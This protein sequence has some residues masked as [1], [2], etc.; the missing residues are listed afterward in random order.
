MI[1]V[2]IVSHRQ[3]LLVEALISDL[4]RYCRD[5]ELMV[6]LNV[7][8]ADLEQELLERFPTLVFRNPAPAGFGTNHNRAFARS[9][10]E[11]FCVLNPD[12]RLTS[13]PFPPLLEQLNLSKVGIAAPR[14]IDPFGREE[15]N[16]RPFP[17]PWSLLGKALGFPR[18]RE[19]HTGSSAFSPDWVAGIFMVFQRDSFIRVGGFDER[20][21]LYYEDVD[22]CARMRLQGYDIRLDPRASVVH[23]ARRQSHRDLRYLWWHVRSALTYFSSATHRRA[24]AL[25]G[26]R[27]E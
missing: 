13:D 18:S 19:R 15:D 10:G 4:N 16:A 11:Y 20:Y 21:F 27:D 2:S 9:S 22:L 23:A 12:V 1:S 26:S 6:T 25:R 5:L 14:V 8:E 17:T 24:R 7:Q 3:A